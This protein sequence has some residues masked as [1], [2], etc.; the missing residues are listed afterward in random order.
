MECCNKQTKKN[1]KKKNKISKKNISPTPI[2][3]LKNYTSEFEK[4]K[5]QF[6]ED[7][8]NNIAFEELCTQLLLKIDGIETNGI[9]KIREIRKKLI[10]DINKILEE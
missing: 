4:L 1:Q 5:K 9:V 7:E 10:V 2:K 3:I 8:I 6:Q